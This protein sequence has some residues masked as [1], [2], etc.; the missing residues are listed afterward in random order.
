MKWKG[1]VIAASLG[2]ASCAPQVDSA[3][4]GS[5]SVTKLKA[6]MALV[7]ARVAELEASTRLSKVMEQGVSRAYLDP[8]SDGYSTARTGIGPLLLSFSSSSPKADGTEIVLQ[9]GNPTA[10]SLAGAVFMVDYNV[11]Q[12]TTSEW[13]ASVKSTEYRSLNVIRAGSWNKVT[14]PLPGIKPDELGYLAISVV[15]NEVR[16][17]AVAP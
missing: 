10:A 14:I 9:V 17:S 6:D 5:A 8:L 2:S 1:I 3:V 15:T 16:L 4:A 13:G 12:D 7:E 11:R